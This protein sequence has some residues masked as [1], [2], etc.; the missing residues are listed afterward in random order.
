MLLFISNVILLDGWRRLGLAFAAGAIASLGQA[1]LGW[2]PLLW[3]A[4]PLLVWLL[5]SAALGKKGQKAA[6]AM[7]KVGWSFGFGFFLL[8]FYW[9][10]AAFLVEADKFAWAMPLA[11]VIL[12]AGLSL[13]WALACG[14]VAFVW[15]SAFFRVFWLVLALSAVEWLRGFVLTGLPWGGFGMALAS[16]TVTMQI[17]SLIGPDGLTLWAILLFAAPVLWLDPSDHQKFGRIVALSLGAIFILQ[18]NYGF[19]RL[20]LSNEPNPEAPVVRLVQPNIPQK[21]KWKIENRAWIFNR[22]LAL[23]TF[24]GEDTPLDAVDLVIWP[25]SALPFYLLEQPGALGAIAQSLPPE[26][27]LLTGALRREQKPDGTESVYNSVYHLNA[28]GT[29]QGAYDKMH[30]VPFGEYLP[31]QDWLE[32]LGLEQLTAQ[33]SGFQSGSHRTLLDLGKWGSILPIICYEVAFSSEILSYPQ[34]AA[35][36]VNVTN[37]A[38]FGSTSGPWQHLQL[39]RMRAVETGLPM[40]RVANTGVTALIDSTGQIIDHLSLEKDGILQ[41]KVPPS[42][43]KTMYATYGNWLF[44]CIWVLLLLTTLGFGRKLIRT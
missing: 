18:I 26:A 33:K 19:F 43:P 20:G 7:A 27:E 13:F 15:S 35:W 37:D 16:Q 4:V 44:L 3:I 28:A 29:I 21:E 5:D 25:E 41:Q 2:F 9:L 11:I 40:V 30:L 1:P 10:G 38:W 36:I 17:L 31:K 39:S 42:L 14:L 8:T 6:W 23:T 22:L 32:A 12:P 34:G 24:D